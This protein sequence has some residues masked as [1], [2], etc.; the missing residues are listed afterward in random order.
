MSLVLIQEPKVS[1]NGHFSNWSAVQMPMVFKFQRQDQQAQMQYSINNN[2]V[3][4]TVGNVSQY[5]VVG[6]RIIYVSG[7]GVRYLF[8]ITNIQGN[9]IFTNGISSTMVNGGYVIY[10]DG[11]KNYYINTELFDISQN[12][13]YTSVGIIEV[14]TDTLGIATIN[15]SEWLSSLGLFSNT[16][17]YD[18]INKAIKGEGGRYQIRTTELFTGSNG[19]ASTLQGVRYWT[20][21]AKQIQE[22]YGVNMGD[23]VP[24]LDDTRLNRAKFLTDFVKPTYFVGFPFSLSFIYSDNLLNKQISRKQDSFDINGS[25]IGGTDSANLDYA[26]RFFVNRLMINNAL[27]SSVNEIDVW[28]ESGDDVLGDEV[29]GGGYVAP[30]VFEPVQPSP[31]PPKSPNAHQ[32]QILSELQ[33]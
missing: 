32:H 12:N 31:A 30:G 8:T 13:Q 26:Q 11:K 22:V 10:I 28:L 1:V 21:S 6:D 4:K 18:Q 3:I 19:V 5:A 27:T 16:F 7:Y 9:N 2:A 14:K 23:Y 29:S 25:Q 20:N 24:T 15:V 33:P 17:D